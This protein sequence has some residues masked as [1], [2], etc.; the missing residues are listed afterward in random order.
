MTQ[1]FINKAM[2][3]M[4]AAITG[5]I[6]PYIGQASELRIP[7]IMMDIFQLMSWS[8]GVVIAIITLLKWLKNRKK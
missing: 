3:S 2:L 4:G 8:A 7:P 1:D 6:A 5:T